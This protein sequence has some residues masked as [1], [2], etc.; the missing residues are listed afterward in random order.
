MS[1][2]SVYSFIFMV[3]SWQQLLTQH[4]MISLK[5]FKGAT[6]HRGSFRFHLPFAA[7]GKAT[8][9][10]LGLFSSECKAGVKRKMKGGVMGVMSGLGVSPSLQFLMLNPWVRKI[11]LEEEMTTHSCVLAWRSPWTEEPGGLQSMGSQ[12]WT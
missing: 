11:P 10:G 5:H 1:F 2:N 12:S 4:K 3:I 6:V 9:L 7:R 8:S